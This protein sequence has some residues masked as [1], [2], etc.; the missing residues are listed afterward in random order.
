MRKFSIKLK[1]REKEG[2]SLI[3][4]YPKIVSVASMISLSIDSVFFFQIVRPPFSTTVNRGVV[5]RSIYQFIQ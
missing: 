3:S 4:L 5:P 2:D 1:Q